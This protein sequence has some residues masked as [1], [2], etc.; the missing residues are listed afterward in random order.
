ME[1]IANI[2]IKIYRVFFPGGYV[3][4]KHE[5]DK[6]IAFERAGLLFVINFHPSKSFADYRIGVETAGVYKLILNS[7]DPLFGGHNLL[8]AD[9]EYFTTDQPY[10]GRRNSLLVYIPS[11]VGI[12][13]AKVR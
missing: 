6:V 4:W 7:D 9:T 10:A 8:N 13:L 12:I 11:R 5:D 3:S 2:E 1:T